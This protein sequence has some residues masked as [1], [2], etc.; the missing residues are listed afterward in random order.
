[1]D[2]ERSNSS[3]PPTTLTNNIPLVASFLASLFAS[4]L[5]L[6]FAS[7]LAAL[8]FASLISAAMLLK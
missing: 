8:L 5:A 1:M 6:L 3:I 2:E 4:L 7:P